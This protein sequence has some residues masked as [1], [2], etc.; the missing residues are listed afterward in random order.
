MHFP[1]AIKILAN[2][3]V[4]NRQD[5]RVSVG[6]KKPL[7]RR[8]HKRQYTLLYPGKLCH[9]YETINLTSFKAFMSLHT[10]FLVP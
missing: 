3:I 7:K 8:R 10:S 9:I 5:E 6:R 2:Q 1:F 4:C